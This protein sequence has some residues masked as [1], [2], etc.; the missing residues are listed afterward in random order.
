LFDLFGVFL[1]RFVC[2]LTRVSL[3]FFRYADA[4][5]RG[6]GCTAVAALLTH[7]RKIYV[8]RVVAPFYPISRVVQY[9][10]NLLGKRW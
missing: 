9:S 3:F 7:D 4:E 1:V 8:V 5:D 6:S 10:H 2:D